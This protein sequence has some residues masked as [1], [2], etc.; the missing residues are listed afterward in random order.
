MKLV[1][2]KVT[3]GTY[4]VAGI[5]AYALATLVIKYD[6]T[7]LMVVI[8]TAVFTFFHMFSIKVDSMDPDNP[9]PKSKFLRR[10][11][12]PIIRTKLRKAIDQIDNPLVRFPLEMSLFF[13]MDYYKDRWINYGVHP[14]NVMLRKQERRL[15][16]LQDREKFAKIIARRDVFAY[17][18]RKRKKMDDVW[19]DAE[20][21]FQQQMKNESINLDRTEI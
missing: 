1:Q 6:L 10:L 12:F 7:V 2:R 5:F 18:S 13:G 21:I 3:I 19:A 14:L 9:A 4:I 20:R 8:W 16:Q 11:L 15:R 17:R